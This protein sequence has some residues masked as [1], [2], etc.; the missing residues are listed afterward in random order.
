MMPCGHIVRRHVDGIYIPVACCMHGPWSSCAVWLQL[1]L[2]KLGLCRDAGQ[3][4]WS[5]DCEV[6]V[7]SA[8][9]TR[10]I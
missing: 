3:G 9:S 8:R 1:S 6:R 4:L 10:L 5:L 2:S 7:L